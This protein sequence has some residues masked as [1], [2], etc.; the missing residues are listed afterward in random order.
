MPHEIGQRSKSPALAGNGGQEEALPEKVISRRVNRADLLAPWR[1][2]GE[3]E[4]LYKLE[5]AFKVFAGFLLQA[6]QESQED[7]LHSGSQG[8]RVEI[9]EVALQELEKVGSNGQG[10]ERQDRGQA[11]E[12]ERKILGQPVLPNDRED[13]V[14]DLEGFLVYPGREGGVQALG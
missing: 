2:D 12:V 1:T 6:R 10:S 3:F 5:G 7:R 14:V 8:A 4:T 11:G 9:K 13:I